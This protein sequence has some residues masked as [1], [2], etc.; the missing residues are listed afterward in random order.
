[1]LGNENTD[2]ESTPNMSWHLSQYQ[3]KR[4]KFKKMHGLINIACISVSDLKNGAEMFQKIKGQEENTK[5]CLEM[6]EKIQNE[7]YDKAKQEWETAKENSFD[8]ERVCE[9]LNVQQLNG[10]RDV[11]ELR[12]KAEQHYTELREKEKQKQALKEKHHNIIIGSSVFIVLIT[13]F[14]V[15]YIVPVVNIIEQFRWLKLDSMTKLLLFLYHWE[16]I[17]IQ[18]SK[19]RKHITQ[20]EKQNFQQGTGIML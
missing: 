12:Q 4:A 1:M 2:Y 7:A 18:N 3:A 13:I 5:S 8:W 16:N 19:L 17:V 20:R 15:F 10:Y 11:N 9:K 14:T 6:A